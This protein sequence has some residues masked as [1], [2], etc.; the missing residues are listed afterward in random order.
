M[1]QEDDDRSDTTDD[2]FREQRL[3]CRM[4]VLVVDYVLQGANQYIDG[5]HHGLRPGEDGLE[6]EGHD[7]QKEKRA[8]YWV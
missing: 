6:E 5:I 1:G 8:P 2:P 7:A 4:Y 3:Q